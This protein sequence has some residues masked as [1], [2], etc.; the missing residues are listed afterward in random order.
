MRWTD[1]D[2]E[3]AD[4]RERAAGD[5]DV[6]QGVVRRGTR[7]AAAGQDPALEGHPLV[8]RV[9]AGLEAAENV[10]E[11]SCL[12]LR[13]EAD[14][15]EVD[16]EQRDVDLDHGPGCSQERAVTA[17][18]DEDVGRRELIAQGLVVAGLRGPLLD[19]PDGA[20]ARGALAELD[21]GI[22]RGVVGEADPADGHVA[23]TVAIWP[24]RSAQ[25]APRC[26]DIRNSRFPSGPRIGEAITP[27]TPSPRSWA[28]AASR[29]RTSR[30]IAGSRT[31][32]LSVRPLPASNWG[33]TSATIRAA[34]PGFSVDATGSRTRP[35]EMNETS[36]TA[37]S[38]ASGSVSAVRARAFVRSIDSTRSS[39]RSDSA[40][41]PLPTSTA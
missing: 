26:T 10:L 8:D 23:V 41:W 40:S 4:A 24:A 39:R 1:L 12:G 13:Q 30:W 38:T 6:V 28:V 22:A 14:L 3:P 33:L 32:P 11:L 34:A 16:P 2:V 20:P 27:W 36:T 29:S 17:K 7:G 21:R 15:A 31:T 18:D 5:D 25:P 19:T 35:R 37:R 9:L